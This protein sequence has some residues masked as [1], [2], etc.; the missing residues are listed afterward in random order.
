MADG[1]EK[2]F[3][4]QS[5]LQIQNDPNFTP[6]ISGFSGVHQMVVEA[7]SKSDIDI[8]RDLFTNIITSGGNSM[9]N[10]FQ[11]RLIKQLPEISPQNVKVKVISGTDRRF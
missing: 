11:D 8:R 3:Q 10:G 4:N 2:L 1:S 7:I 9:L 5:S 6:E